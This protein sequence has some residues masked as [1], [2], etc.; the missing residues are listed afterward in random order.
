MKKLPFISEC[1][2]EISKKTWDKVFFDDE[3]WYAWY[4]LYKNWKKVF[5][6]DT[7]FDINGSWS[8]RIAKDKS[9]TKIFLSKLWY[10]V[11]IWDVFFSEELNIKLQDK[12]TID[13]WYDYAKKLWFPLIVKPNNL[14]QWKFV[15]KIYSKSE[16]YSLAKKILKITD[17][18]VVEKFC[19]WNDYRILVLDNIVKLCYERKNLRIIWDWK[20]TILDLINKKNKELIEKWSNARVNLNSSFIIKNLKR[21]WFQLSS[22]LTDWYELKLLDNANLSSWWELIDHIDDIHEDFKKLAINVTKEMWLRYCWVDILT[23]DITKPI[24]DYNIIEIN[25]FPWFKNYSLAW[26]RNKEIAKNLCYE[27]FLAM[28]K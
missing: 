9:Y 2:L 28:W 6:V 1:F 27:I 4:V 22:V 3:Y 26:E 11:P 8:S 15:W 16:Y 13:D 21:K 5:F 12:K 14:H 10:N 20:K 17:T 19:E 24:W 23:N 18:L 7:H 25:A